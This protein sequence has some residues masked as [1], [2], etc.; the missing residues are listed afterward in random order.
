MNTNGHTWDRRFLLLAEQIAGWSKDPSSKVGAVAVKDR[1][2]LATGFNGFPVGVSDD[3]RLY[4]RAAKYP[5]VVHAE[6]NVVAWAAREGISLLG[7]TLYVSPFH[8][9]QDC[10]KLLVQAG[11]ARIVHSAAPTPERWRAD[12]DTANQILREAGLAVHALAIEG[13]QV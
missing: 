4:D 6:A 7:S 8:P 5:R 12:F 3:E 9:C 2:L 1:R 10:A 13:V 11:I